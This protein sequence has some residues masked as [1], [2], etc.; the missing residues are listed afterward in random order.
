MRYQDIGEKVRSGELP[1]DCCG[2]SINDSKERFLEHLDDQI[3]NA[4]G[5][6]DG[7]WN[8]DSRRDE[9][10]PE[11]VDAG[12]R[13]FYQRMLDYDVEEG[14]SLCICVHEQY[15]FGCGD[16]F[17]WVYDGDCLRL[18]YVYGDVEI[19]PKDH[20]CEYENPVPF[21][22]ELRVASRL[23]FANWFD[24][25]DHTDEDE[26][27]PHWSLNCLQGRHNITKF[28]A[29]QNILYGQT[30]NSSFSVYINP[31][32]T[33][34]IIA[35]PYIGE[36]RAEKMAEEQNLTDEQYDALDWDELNTI[37]GHTKIGDEYVSMDVWRWEATDLA[38]LGDEKYRLLKNGDGNRYPK[39]TI[40]LD[41]QHGIWQMEHFFDVIR[42]GAR[43]DDGTYARITLKQE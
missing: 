31:E 1:L 2:H 43:E 41:V 11:E 15:C 36:Q 34:I 22:A 33:S 29:A 3:A 5:A 39:D 40:E 23:I 26:Y 9:K 16:R 21:T 28:K 13:D 6:H 32:R 8:Y 18:R 12:M 14:E 25:P 19:L 24:F 37:D 10:T 35:S 38:T 20:R 30:T 7:K 17:K 27:K 42:H 4:A